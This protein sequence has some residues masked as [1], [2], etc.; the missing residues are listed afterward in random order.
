MPPRSVGGLAGLGASSPSASMILDTIVTWKRSQE[1]PKLPAVDRTLLRDLPATRGFRHALDRQRQGPIRVIAEC[2]KGSPSKGV[3]AQDYDPVKQ[4]FFYHA[5]GA[6]ALSILTDEHFFLGKLDDLIAVR[7][8]VTL[9]IIRKDFI[10]DPRQIAQ[11]RLVGADAILLIAA[12][13]EDGEMRD[14]AGFAK[15]LSLDVLCEVHDEV[16]AQRAVALGMNLIGVNNRNLQTFQVDVGTTLRLLPGLI[17][18][19]RIVVSESG[20][21]DRATCKLLEDAGVDAILVGEHLMR[22]KDPGY[23]LERLRG[24]R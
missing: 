5:G 14:L 23:D 16:E 12:C 20:I 6:S 13:L 10:L 22:S 15:D 11:A 9:P 3:I 17:G 19:G 2:K 18:S 21:Q 24:L 7:A 1:L 4:A 8:N